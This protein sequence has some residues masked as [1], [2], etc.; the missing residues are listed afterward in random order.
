MGRT[1]SKVKKRQEYVELCDKWK[2]RGAER[3]NKG[4]EKSLE[5]TRK[6]LQIITKVATEEMGRTIVM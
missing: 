5:E 3:Y 4:H 2:M 1:K 6:G